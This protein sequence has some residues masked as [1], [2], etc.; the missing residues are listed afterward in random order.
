MQQLYRKVQG[1]KVIWMITIILS[2][3]S[4]VAVYSAISTL[5]YKA[6][7]NSL[8]FLV[9]H[10]AMIGLGLGTMYVVHLTRFKYFSRI[11]VVLLSVA[12]A[13]LL[14]TLMFGPDI[15]HAKRWLK[16]PG[17]G[18]TFQTS[19]FAK[20][21]LVTWV[22]HKLNQ[23]RTMLH[24]FRQG[25]LPILLPV[26]GICAL[27]VVADFSTAALLFGVCYLLFFIGGVPVKHLLR[28]AG[29]GVAGIAMMLLLGKSFPELLPRADTWVSRI[30]SFTEPGDKGNYQSN[31]AQVAIYKGGLIPNGPGSSS[32]RNYLPHP[33]SDM[34]YA[35]IIEEYGALLGG[36]SL[37]LLYLILLYRSIRIAL[38]CPKHFGG[39]LALGLSFLLVS[40]AL[41]N[42]AVAVG[43]FPV[44][45]QPLPLVSMGG[46]SMIFTCLAI[47]MILSV[48]RSV[49][50]IEEYGEDQGGNSPAN[51]QKNTYAPA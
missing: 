3:L 49:Y 43:L 25:V 17:L 51:T 21:V 35:F 47:G 5:A 36:L 23:N 45:G 39:L 33:Y 48:S 14:L 40:Q 9:K 7:G 26:A 46:T 42:M 30:E 27:I 10:S 50:N 29:L 1:D 22:A 28:I 38:K 12:A 34:I 13:V 11:S 4:L 8:K 31:F 32:A 16:I 6:E 18:L 19:D 37:I 20:I 15:N 2:L 24:D 41:I 44:T